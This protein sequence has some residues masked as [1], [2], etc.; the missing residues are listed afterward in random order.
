VR[1]LALGTVNSV[2]INDAG[3]KEISHLQWDAVSVYW[4]DLT[5]V[6]KFVH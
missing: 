5:S 2:V 3:A 1:K 4:H 6:R